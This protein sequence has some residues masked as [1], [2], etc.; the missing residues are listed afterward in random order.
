[1]KK[2]LNYSNEET[3]NNN[4]NVIRLCEYNLFQRLK[5]LLC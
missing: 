2:M 4:N 3:N 5:K 1:M